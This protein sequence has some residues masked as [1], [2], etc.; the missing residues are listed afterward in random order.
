MMDFVD[1]SVGSPELLDGPYY[2]SGWDIHRSRSQGQSRGLG[3]WEY[4]Q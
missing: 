2:C 3:I 4:L 1:D